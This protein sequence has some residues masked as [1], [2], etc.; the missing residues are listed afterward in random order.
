[1]AIPNLSDAQ[2]AGVIWQVCRYIEEQQDA[3]RQRAVPLKPGEAAAVTPFFPASTLDRARIVVL[4]G[5]R[6]HNPHFYTQ[7]VQMGFDP[8]SL[9][10]FE[11]MTAV[12]FVDTIVSN[13]VLDSRVLF[14][15]LVHVH[16]Y[17]RLGLPD[18]ASRYVK[19]FLRSGTYEG[20][21]LEQNAYELDR[22]FTAAPGKP[23][24]VQGEVQAW[25]DE[26]RF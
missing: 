11:T 1:M 24:S 10:D 3:H 6:I 5:E 16:Q 21:P 7:L 8:R 25:I 20:I 15:E 4:Q 18:F 13:E 17:E 14:H 23:F 22:R 9:P 12:T 2:I 19:G 26:N